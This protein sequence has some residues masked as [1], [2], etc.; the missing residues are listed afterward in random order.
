MREGLREDGRVL[1]LRGALPKAD[2]GHIP[3]AVDVA[4]VRK[5]VKAV[6]AYEIPVTRSALTVAMLTA[7]RPGTVARMEWAE[8]D[9]D[10]GEWIIPAHKIGH[11]KCSLSRRVLSGSNRHGN[12]SG[13]LSF[14]V[15]SSFQLER[16]RGAALHRNGDLFAD[17]GAAPAAKRLVRS[18]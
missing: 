12:Q 5:L 14:R 18:V 17:T 6:A 3:A 7:Q 15:D 16:S 8:V 1:S 11:C 4:D 2:K 13:R 10:A 9:L